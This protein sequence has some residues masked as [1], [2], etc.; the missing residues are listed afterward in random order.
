MPDAPTRFQL[1]RAKGWR[2][3]PGGLSVARPT[4]WGNRW[5][6]EVV[7]GVG[8]C[9]TDTS[10][11]LIVQ[12]RDATDA[13]ALAVSHFRAWL[14]SQPDLVAAA[15]RDLRGRHLGCWCD[16]RMPCHGNVWIEVANA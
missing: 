1:S 9:C 3:P 8:W 16:L 11:G 2:M 12:A 15:R 4:R 13:H 10:T 14:P 6:A 5:R 7:Q